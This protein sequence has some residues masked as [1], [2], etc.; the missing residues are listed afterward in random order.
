DEQGP[1]EDEPQ[2]DEQ[3]EGEKREGPSPTL[4]APTAPSDRPLRRNL[5]HTHQELGELKWAIRSPRPNAAP[6]RRAE[7]RLPPLSRQPS[8]GASEP[9]LSDPHLSLEEADVADDLLH[10][11]AGYA[12][13][14]RH[15]A[16]AP[17]VGAN[18]PIDRQLK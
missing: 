3:H 2:H 16:E 6:P 8:H 14:R 11:L 1:P 4:P 9:N 12:G 17:M 5:D 15:I 18:P 10:L 7:D 13:H